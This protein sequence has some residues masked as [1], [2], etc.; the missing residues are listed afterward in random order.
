[1]LSPLYDLC[2]DRFDNILRGIVYGQFIDDIKYRIRYRSLESLKR[3]AASNKMKLSDYIINSACKR[4]R[5]NKLNKKLYK[6]KIVKK[7]KD[8]DKYLFVWEG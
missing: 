6:N 5:N 4:V 3:L 8:T 7:Y 1:M 2:G